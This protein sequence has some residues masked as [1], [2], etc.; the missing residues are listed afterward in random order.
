MA[1]HMPGCQHTKPNGLKFKLD[2]KKNNTPGTTYY[3]CCI[4]RV[5]HFMAHVRRRLQQPACGECAWLFFQ[6]P[7][8]AIK[9]PKFDLPIPVT[10]DEYVAGHSPV[11]STDAYYQGIDTAR[12][13]SNPL[14]NINS[15]DK[16]PSPKATTIGDL[17]QRLARDNEAPDSNVNNEQTSDSKRK[18]YIPVGGSVAE[19]DEDGD[20]VMKDLDSNPVIPSLVRIPIHSF[21]SVAEFIPYEK[22][23]VFNVRPCD[24]H[25]KLHSIFLFQYTDINSKHLE[26]YFEPLAREEGS[27]D[28]L[29]R[30][31]RVW[32]CWAQG[33][34]QLEPE[35]RWLLTLIFDLVNV[36][37]SKQKIWGYG[38]ESALFW[39]S[40]IQLQQLMAVAKDLKE[41]F[42][43]PN[44]DIPQVEWM[45]A[46]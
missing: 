23:A 45:A 16:L 27:C 6:I 2:H 10:S 21:Q 3:Y 17:N 18:H 40:R 25:P 44:F 28:A 24:W 20:V 1:C 29:L 37:I 26:L 12:P 42:R 13:V 36:M 5:Y 4:H 22:P 19:R 32:C 41:M 38:K 43:I 33:F 34:D 8:E 30:T 35:L 14:G 15:D 39:E 11:S 46:N 31:I 7:K 9:L